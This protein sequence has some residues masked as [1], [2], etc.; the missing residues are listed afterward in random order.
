MNEAEIPS[1]KVILIGDTGVG[2]T[3]LAIRQCRGQFSFQMAPTIGIN[4]MKT[5]VALSDKKVELKI[6]DTAGQENFAPLLTTYSRGA[7]VCIIVASFVDPNSQENLEKWHQR[8]QANGEN[9]PIVVAINKIDMQEGA[10]NTIE[11]IREKYEQ[12]FPNLFFVSSRTG[13]GVAELFSCVADEAVKA[14]S[15]SSPT[16]AVNLADESTKSS[17]NCC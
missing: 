17:N 14:N 7:Q 6:W 9:P 1:Y 3:S 16:K 4:H 11:Q 12:Q 13:D 15:P 8:L 5:V 2:K 10:Q